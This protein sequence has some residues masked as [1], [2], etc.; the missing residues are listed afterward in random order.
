MELAP[1]ETCTGCM[2]C[3]EA[4]PKKCISTE[5]DKMGNVF[6]S[7]DHAACVE[8][9]KC[10][11]VCPVVHRPEGKYPSKAY[12]VWSLD[13]NDRKSSASGGAASVFY[14]TAVTNGFWIVGTEYDDS[15]R[16][17]H[18]MSDSIESIKK[19]K[20]SKYV[21]SDVGNL[22]GE[23]KEKLN[24]EKKVLFIS[25]P[26]KVA[27]LL[28]YLQKPYDNLVTVDIVCH[29]TPSMDLLKN[30]IA[31]MIGEKN[32]YSLKFR[33]DNQYIFSLSNKDGEELYYSVGKTDTYLAAFVECLDFRPSCYQCAFA[34]PERISDLTICDFWGLGQEIPFEHP[35]TG[36]ISA[37]MV[38]TAKGADFF[39]TCRELLFVEERPVE[40][41]IKGNAQL[42]APSTPHP[43]RQEFEELF[44]TVG[45]EEAVRQVLSVEMR[46]EKKR[47]F[48]QRVRS[49]VRKAAG[50]FIKRYRS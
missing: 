23:I 19:Y 25:L 13:S 42:N 29:G 48:W 43:R 28:Q 12:A 40:E 31:A 46:A 9:G 38:N 34:K 41:A 20:Q 2:A 3:Q 4:C 14:Q 6:T 30:H 45:F 7:I 50:I 35:Y 11:S 44:E 36:A 39:E 21:F 49:E 5:K 27:G 8:C 33:Q 32:A 22:Y 17:I 1:K 16:V 24:K 47:L 26:C 18:S 10:Q 15:F 37:V